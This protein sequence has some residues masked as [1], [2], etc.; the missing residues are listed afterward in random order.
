MA[1]EE[2]L[3]GFLTVEGP[4]LEA[5]YAALSISRGEKV[6]A[7]YETMGVFHDLLIRDDEGY[8]IAECLGEPVVSE[9]KLFMFREEVLKLSERL[10]AAK[11]IPIKEARIVS[12]S[13]PDEWSPD[14]R[15]MLQK[16]A[17]DL[18]KESIKLTFIEPRRII[19]DL[20]MN[21][22]LGLSLF[23][24]HIFFVGPGESA[25]RY[26]PSVSKFGISVSPIDFNEYR[27][28]PHSF[29]PR[30]YW[31]NTHKAIFEEYAVLSGEPL[32]EW[33]DWKLPD[34]LGITW[35]SVEQMKDALIHSFK[36]GDREL[37]YEK[38][39][40]FITKRLLK[41]NPYYTANL[42]YHRHMIDSNDAVSI[43]REMNE[44]IKAAKE[45]GKISEELE[46]YNRLFTDTITFTHS[47]WYKARYMSYHGKVSYTEILRGEDVLMET[48][49]SGI[50]GF[51]LKNGRLTLSTEES[52]NTLKIV[53]GG[54]HWESELRSVYP[55][56]LRF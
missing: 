7:R 22:I 6:A 2:D 16:L 43:E 27:K 25:I 4:L 3:D 10:R 13:T 53:N 35:K 46:F 47:Y 11:D 48:L 38:A 23:D 26:Q 12:I 19:Y 32:P 30:I 18:E 31:S 55:A 29:M 54:L 33:F 24:N 41:K 20:I 9:K 40:G 37:V 45:V 14:A 50:L 28:L 1:D 15:E 49:N 8:I 34:H 52:P 39:N 17:S 51:K 5:A 44:L 36:H 56:Q 42:V 21:S